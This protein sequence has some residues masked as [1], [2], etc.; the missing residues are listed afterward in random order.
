[1][2]STFEYGYGGLFNMP[3]LASVMLIALLNGVALLFFVRKTVGGMISH[4]AITADT[5]G[6][7]GL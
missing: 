7:L 2:T 5:N 6:Y 3:L 4:P 1:M